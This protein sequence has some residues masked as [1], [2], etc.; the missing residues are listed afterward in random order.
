MTRTLALLAPLALL[1]GCASPTP[2]EMS[3]DAESELAELL[4][5]RVPGE[6]VSC[7]PPNV[8]SSTVIDERTVV[9]RFGGTRYLQ[10]FNA[11]CNGLDRIGHVLVIESPLGRT[12]SGDIAKVYET[13]TGMYGGFCAFNDFIPYRDAD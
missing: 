13:A 3:P 11:D 2:Y 1:G 6:P 5:D 10:T 9:Y 12:C 7:L 4:G 8:T